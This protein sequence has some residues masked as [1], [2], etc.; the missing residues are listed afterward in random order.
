ME[1][2]RLEP[3]YC[4]DGQVPPVLLFVRRLGINPYGVG[5]VSEAMS[6]TCPTSKRKC[7]VFNPAKAISGAIKGARLHPVE[8]KTINKYH[9]AKL[10]PR[11]SYI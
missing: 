10:W 9:E 7:K 8:K 11:Q 3:H 2:G 6:G 1:E 4:N 5:I